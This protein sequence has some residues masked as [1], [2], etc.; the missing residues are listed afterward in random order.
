MIVRDLLIEA[1]SRAGDIRRGQKSVSQTELD[2]A[3]TQFDSALRKYS[4][5][6]MITAFQ[7]ILD[8][9]PVKTETTIGDVRWTFDEGSERTNVHLYADISKVTGDEFGD[10]QI[11]LDLLTRKLYTNNIRNVTG[12]VMVVNSG[13]NPITIQDTIEFGTTEEGTQY[14]NVTDP[15]RIV[16]AGSSREV[17]VGATQEMFRDGLVP[18][19]DDEVVHGDGTYTFTTRTNN[20][21]R[22]DITSN[23][24]T[25]IAFEPDIYCPDMQRCMHVMYLSPTSLWAK[26][27]YVPL[28]QFFTDIDYEIY[29]DQPIGLGKIKLYLP[30]QMIGTYLSGDNVIGRQIKMVYNANMKFGLD[31]YLDLPELHL[32]LLTVAVEVA[33]LSHDGDANPQVLQLAQQELKDIEDNIKSTTISNRVIQRDDPDIRESLDSLITGSFLRRR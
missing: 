18:N 14:L 3:K 12:Y 8:F 19:Q 2:D 26:L 23:K 29:C 16:A 30:Y 31:D 15:D 28:H 10:G 11:G 24:S 33:L 20:W 5:N 25:Y 17:I 27:R 9:Q 1:L 13:E 6:N 4:D 21:N 7:K 22:W 32:E